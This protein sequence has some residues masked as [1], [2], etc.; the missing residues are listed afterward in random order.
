MASQELIDQIKAMQ[1]EDYD[2][3]LQWWAYCDEHGE[4][5]KDPA[6]HDDDFING[7]LTFF[8]SGER[9]E[10]RDPKKGKG[11]KGSKGGGKGWS[12]GWNDSWSDGGGWN[13][14]G[15]NGGKGKG[16]G[17]SPY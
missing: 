9:L 14:G 13:D 6:R 3:K 17:W 10:V 16:K 1:R 15:W 8:N 11:G 2:T 5:N 4:G 7:F 12:G